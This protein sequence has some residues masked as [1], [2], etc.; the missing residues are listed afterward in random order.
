M[1]GGACLTPHV[2]SV[3]SLNRVGI[4]CNTNRRKH[5]LGE[6]PE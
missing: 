1:E 5:L 3:P 2:R 6:R 4:P